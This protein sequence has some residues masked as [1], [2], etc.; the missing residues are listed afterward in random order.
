[1][2]KFQTIVAAIAAPLLTSITHASYIADA[3]TGLMYYEYGTQRFTEGQD[4]DGTFNYSPS[5]D[6]SYMVYEW[7]PTINSINRITYRVHLYNDFIFE[8]SVQLTPDETYDVGHFEVTS[9]SS[10][11]SSIRNLMFHTSDKGGY[12][13]T[14]GAFDILQLE[15]DNEGNIT[16]YAANLFIYDDSTYFSQPSDTRMGIVLRYNS[17]YDWCA[18]I[19]DIPEPA[20]LSLITLGSLAL[21]TRSRKHV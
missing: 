20:S 14:S 6:N 8:A 15:H 18:T 3:Y 13:M 10:Y 17:D 21:L 1:M 11:D 9:G 4:R 7:Q 12:S 16:K 19:N 5:F 2:T